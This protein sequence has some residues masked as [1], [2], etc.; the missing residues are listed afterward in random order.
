MSFVA[1]ALRM[2]L[3]FLRGQ[4]IRIGRTLI[5][6]RAPAIIR[7]AS[8]GKKVVIAPGTTI[9]SGNRIRIGDNSFIGTGCLLNGEGGIIIGKGAFLAPRVMI[10]SFS[11][12]YETGQQIPYDHH[13]IGELVSI[14]DYV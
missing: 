12:N 8:L 11:H 13:K 10:I 3:R 2:I 14:G 5:D 7:F 4:P 6:W 1:H 9:S